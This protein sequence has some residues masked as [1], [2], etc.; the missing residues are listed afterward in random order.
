MRVDNKNE[1]GKS[2][3]V[4]ADVLRCVACY[5]VISIHFLMNSGFYSTTVYGKKMFLAVLIRCACTICVPLFLI[6]SGYLM[7][8]VFTEP[9]ILYKKN[10]NYCC[11]YFSKY[12]V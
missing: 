12:N 7:N 4:A 9:L 10:K 2:R 5:L 8:K 3:M 11:L 6:L 1:N